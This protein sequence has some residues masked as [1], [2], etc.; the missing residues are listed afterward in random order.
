[1]QN[2]DREASPVRRNYIVRGHRK[3]GLIEWLQEMLSHS[4]VLNASD[5][6]PDTMRDFEALVAEHRGNPQSSRLK[7]LVPSVGV[8][9][10][11]LP[12]REAFHIYDAKY[13]ISCRKHIPPSFNEVR[14]IL[15][16][17]QVIALGGDLSLITFDGDQ[18][19]YTD[20]SNFEDSA[21]LALGIVDLLK[22][23]LHV[24]VITAAGYGLDGAKYEVRLR[25]LL[26]A[27]VAQKLSA[28]EM[29]RFYVFGGECNYLLQ[30][31]YSAGLAKT[32]VLLPVPAEVE[33]G[34]CATY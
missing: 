10:T 23:G 4:F 12:M 27:F 8:F 14:H 6:Y 1:M 9:H 31:S 5:T 3:D 30:C 22:F 33:L 7:Q 29:S 17:A 16:L 21:D 15:N 19:L 13:S 28:D 34:F 18:T 11:A 2:M 20:G 24:A 32:A 25:G 26:D